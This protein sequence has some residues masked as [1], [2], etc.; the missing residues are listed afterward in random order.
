MGTQN[1]A[2]FPMVYFF[3]AWINSCSLIKDKNMRK[4]A[5]YSLK[6][7]SES[8][9]ILI[10][11]FIARD[12]MMREKEFSK[13]ILYLIYSILSTFGFSKDVFLIFLILLVSVMPR[14]FFKSYLYLNYDIKGKSLP[15][16]WNIL[17][18]DKKSI[19]P[20]RKI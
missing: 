11:Y 5:V 2:S 8:F 9:L 17:Y 19:D 4:N 12:K 6:W 7:N 10:F 13:N 1:A 15:S 3:A 14:F 18:S 20:L 16:G